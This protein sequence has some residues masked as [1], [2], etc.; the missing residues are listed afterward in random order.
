MSDGQCDTDLDKVINEWFEEA[1]EKELAA[2]PSEED[3]EAIYTP[4]AELDR[5]V[6]ANIKRFFKQQEYP[7]SI[8]KI[9]AWISSWATL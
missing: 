9:R 4:S 1:L 8:K 5:R 2:I 6:S 3:M 7:E